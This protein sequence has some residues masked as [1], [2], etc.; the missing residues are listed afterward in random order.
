MEVKVLAAVFL[1]LFG[2][3]VAMG[4]GELTAD[5]LTDM[6]EIMSRFQDNLQKVGDSGSGILDDIGGG[7]GSGE[8]A[9][10][11]LSASFTASD[12]RRSIQ[13]R[14]KVDVVAVNGSDINISVSGL[15]A[16]P[17]SASIRLRNYTGDLA[18]DGNITMS[19][20][21]EVVSLDDLSFDSDSAESI[22]L[23]VGDPTSLKIDPVPGTDMAFSSVSGRFAS[24]GSFELGDGTAV[25]RSFTGSFQKR[26]DGNYS[27]DGKVYRAVL[28]EGNSRTEIGGSE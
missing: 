25:L 9:N 17:D 3:A 2:M 4:Q 23:Y 5:D 1:T 19:G 16:S 14:E 11:T 8:P 15:D 26:Y 13:M 18:F 24:D 21:A 7:G 28:E 10:T 22:E 12:E 20:T 6:G 27:L